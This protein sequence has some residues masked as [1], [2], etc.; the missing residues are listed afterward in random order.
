ME[1]T[2]LNIQHLQRVNNINPLPEEQNFVPA[3]QFELY[4]ST[5]IDLLPVIIKPNT[6]S[7]G[8]TFG[9]TLQNDDLLKISFINTIQPKYI[10]SKIFSNPG[11]TNNKLRSAF[12]T[13]IDSWELCTH[14]WWWSE[15]DSPITK[16]GG[17][18]II[19]HL[20]NEK[21]HWKRLGNQPMSMAYSTLTIDVTRTLFWNK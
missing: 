1:D 10:S 4:T 6:H 13:S 11:S 16:E 7:S 17:S 14:L 8:P 21:Y 2:P 12:V 20:C 3:S 9:L 18:G 19:T 5:S 15:T